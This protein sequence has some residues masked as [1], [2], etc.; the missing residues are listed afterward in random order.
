MSK[1]AIVTD[2]APKALGPYSAS[3]ASTPPPASLPATT[4]RARPARA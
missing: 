4:S 2:K 1:T 3:W